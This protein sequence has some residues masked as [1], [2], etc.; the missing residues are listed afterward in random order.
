[1]T[2]RA[3]RKTSQKQE[4]KQLRQNLLADIDRFATEFV[5]ND[6]YKRP[7][8]R[9]PKIIHDSL[10]GTIRLHPWEVALL[11]L[12]LFQ[13]LRQ[14]CQTSLVNYVFPG[15]NH[16][17]FEHTLG[18]LSQTQRLIE[19][20]NAQYDN[21]KCVPYD[22][23]LVR[24]LR[25]AALFHDCGHCC[26]SHI[27]ED[28]YATCP[29]LQAL[30]ADPSFPQC[31]PHEALSALILRSAPVRDFLQ[32]LGKKYSVSFGVNRASNWIMGANSARQPKS[33]FATQII[34][35]P[36][37]ADKLDYIFRDAH[38]SG[39]PLGVD[40]YR[41]WAS[42]RVETNKETKERILTLHQASVA[43]L[44][45]ILFS[46]INL[47]SIVYQHPKV[48]A[49]EKMF[50]AVIEDIQNG[51]NAENSFNSSGRV[52]T[53]KKAVDFLWLTDETFFSEAL[54]RRQEDGLH[55]RIHAIQYRRLLVR[56]L[57]I[58]NDT[59][60]R[61][62][63]AGYAQLR[64]LNQR[65]P[66]TYRARRELAEAIVKEACSKNRIQ[67]DVKD[68]WVDIPGDPAYGEADRTFVKTAA[69][70]MRKVSDLFPVHYWS[71]LFQK[72]KWR[73]HV[74]CPASVQQQVYE[75]ALVVF[76]KQYK[77]RFKK[78]AGESA[79][80]QFKVEATGTKQA[81]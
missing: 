14:I 51:S 57:T 77:I 69:G 78:S 13:R 6:Q 5:A 48:R 38:Y 66:A 60:E 71:D 28:L 61:E 37:D 12:P 4:Q 49:A 3:K 15:C 17:R 63:S 20:V 74:F 18:V 40:L 25:L 33:R 8:P 19:A 35:G 59:I 26:F 62:C 44:E 27:S 79:H 56:A 31:H 64:K 29:D 39:I 42:C 53:L 24:D 41:L 16:T 47:F 9:G 22:L 70:G 34:N 68:V 58:S 7:L 67:I 80:V 45:Q 30:F 10:W 75:A 23:D 46:K 52:L 32:Q 21:P 81:G 11:D 50:Q 76:R 2:H 1:M 72:H 55:K 65:G 54:R 36:F 43:P 73:A